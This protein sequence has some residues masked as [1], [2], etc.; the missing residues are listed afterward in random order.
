MHKRKNLKNLLL[1][2]DGYRNNGGQNKL[3]I[4]GKKKW[5]DHETEK[6]FKKLK[7]K[8]HVKFL[9]RVSD[10]EM[11]NI[12]ASSKALCFVSFFEGFGLP[13][14]E[15]MKCETPVI[16]SN[17][18]AMPEISGNASILVNPYCHHEITNAMLKIDNSSNSEMVAKGILNLNR[19]DWCKSAEQIFEIILKAKKNGY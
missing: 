12:L 5:W 19:F 10:N 13:I 14:L 7:S 9:G 4:I 3:L 11:I 18:S 2:F 15:A 6:V 16:C 8:N 17:T 1:A